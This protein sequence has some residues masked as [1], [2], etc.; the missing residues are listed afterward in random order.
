MPPVGRSGPGR[1]QTDGEGSPIE[2]LD[3][4]SPVFRQAAANLMDL[5]GRV[6]AEPGVA[7]RYRE[8]RRCLARYYGRPRGDPDLF[9]RHT[10]VST[11]ARLVG[12]RILSPDSP[13]AGPEGL[14]SVVDGAWFRERDVYNFAEDDFFTWLLHP[15]IAWEATSLCR[16]VMDT[17]GEWDPRGPDTGPVDSLHALTEPEGPSGSTGVS[18]KL[19]EDILSRELRLEDSPASRVLDPACRSGSFVGAAVRL[20]REAKLSAGLDGYDT[21]TQLTSDAAG[22]DGHPAQVAAA[23]AAY[24]YGLGDLVREPHPPVVIP[25]YL[26]DALAPPRASEDD[27]QAPVHLVLE[28]AEGGGYPLP[29]SVAGDP[30]HLDW[31]FHRLAQYVHGAQVR[32]PRQGETEAINAVMG[33]L[34]AYLT[35]PKRSGLMTLPGLD[36][37]DA[38]VMCETARRIIALGLRG[39][40]LLWMYLVKNGA[41]PVHLARRRFDLVLGRMPPCLRR[42]H[43]QA[44]D[45]PVR[46]L[47]RAAGLYLRQGGTAAVA[48]GP[49]EWTDAGSHASITDLRETRIAVTPGPDPWRLVVAAGVLQ[50]NVIA[51]GEQWAR[52]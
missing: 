41:A 49:S 21:L 4:S 9:I 33:P 24:L 37:R 16:G 14:A 39:E 23:R 3:P 30:V 6:A 17:L 51:E 27:G 44:G 36:A 42:P 22:V 50:P 18:A 43:S 10:H 32:A 2:I 34:Y 12:A 1:E 13:P 40:G 31:L 29:D 46:F 38:Q 45:D 48:L 47:D 5:Y 26:A 35:S 7:A 28:H 25:V 11:A 15:R 8:W 19:A 52:E 20:L